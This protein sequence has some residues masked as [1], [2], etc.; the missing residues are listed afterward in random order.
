MKFSIIYEGVLKSNGN[1]KHK[2]DI[3]GNISL[4]LEKLWQLKSM[5][6]LREYAVGNKSASLVDAF[7]QSLDIP[8][9]PPKR[10][11]RGWVQKKNDY[12]FLPV[13]SNELHMTAQIS[14]VWFREEKPGNLMPSGDIDNRLKTLFDALQ[15]PTQDQLRGIS[16]ENNSHNNPFYTVLEDDALISGINVDTKQLLKDVKQN[17]VLLHI[18]VTTQ[19]SDVTLENINFI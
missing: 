7:E 17:E 1:P 14:I 3:R 9:N 4:Q 11:Q 16:I 10:G 6:S 5:Q 2:Q 8:T 12:F 19:V 18:E 15:I 13:V